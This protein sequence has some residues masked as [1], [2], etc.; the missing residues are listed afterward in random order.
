MLLPVLLN[1][2]LKK[3]K[4]NNKCGSGNGSESFR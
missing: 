3:K 2:R 1:I 4:N